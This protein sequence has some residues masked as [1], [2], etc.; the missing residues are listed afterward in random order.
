MLCYVI[1][2]YVTLCC[3]VMLYYIILLWD[4]RRICGPSL[5]ETSLCGA[6]RTVWTCRTLTHDGIH[7]DRLQKTF[8]QSNCK[9]IHSDPN[10][11]PPDIAPPSITAHGIT[12]YYSVFPL[13]AGLYLPPKTA[14]N[15][16]WRYIEVLLLVYP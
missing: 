6:Y 10:T 13:T 16:Q 3:Y 5:T 2:C 4:Y 12:R 9:H 8:C 14:V 15:K 7:A 11:A 1:L